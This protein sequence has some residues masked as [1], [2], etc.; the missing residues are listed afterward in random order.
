MMWF[1]GYFL[2]SCIVAS[3]CIYAHKE[4]GNEWNWAELGVC[5]L[6]SVLS[7]LTIMGT[8][9]FFTDHLVQQRLGRKVN[10]IMW[11]WGREARGEKMVSWDNNLEN[12]KNTEIRYQRMRETIHIL[13]NK[14]LEYLLLVPKRTYDMELAIR[15]AVVDEVIH[16]KILNHNE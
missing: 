2:L 3:A 15:G 11:K 5:A 12:P 7:P 16:R 1:C 13:S 4:E 9:A 6:L 8:A 14:E 10:A